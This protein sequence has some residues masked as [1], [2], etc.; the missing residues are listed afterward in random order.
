MLGK[1]AI[2]EIHHA[3]QELDNA[4]DKLAVKMVQNNETVDHLPCEYS[5]ILWLS[6]VEKYNSSEFP[7]IMNKY[8]SSIG[9]DLASKMPNSQKEFLDYLHV[10]LILSFSIQ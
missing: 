3:G 7:D 8:F 2:R 6:H 4:V 1:P 10:M 9:Y 5:R